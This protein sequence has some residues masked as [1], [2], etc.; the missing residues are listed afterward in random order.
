M[1]YYA[2]APNIYDIDLERVLPFEEYR[3]NQQRK[4]G[5]LH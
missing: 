5:R 1:F 3:E 4:M 2:F